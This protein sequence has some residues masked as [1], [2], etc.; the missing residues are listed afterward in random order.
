MFQQQENVPQFPR[1]ARRGDRRRA[2][3]T[4]GGIEAAGLLYN[5]ILF[6]GG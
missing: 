5:P 2:D 4:D 1:L 3:D 6:E